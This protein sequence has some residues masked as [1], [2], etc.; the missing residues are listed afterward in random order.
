MLRKLFQALLQPGLRDRVRALEARV[1]EVDVEWLDW[2]NKFKSLYARLAKAEIRS[3]AGS[4]GEPEP[5]E[6][7]GERPPVPRRRLN[8]LE[9]AQ[10]VRRNRGVLRPP[11]DEPR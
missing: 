11:V 9:L 3:R 1:E 10:L 5:G 7:D 6:A 8:Q 2:Y 4:D